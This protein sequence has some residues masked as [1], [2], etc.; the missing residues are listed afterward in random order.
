MLLIKNG[1]LHLK[2]GVVKTGWDILTAGK[3]IQSI[4]E[5][6]AAP[7]AE[8]IDATGLQVYP[9]YVLA[10]SAVGAHAFGERAYAHQA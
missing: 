10:L 8:I 2:D 1:T 6:L 7:G 5:N 4:G 9:G 3:Y